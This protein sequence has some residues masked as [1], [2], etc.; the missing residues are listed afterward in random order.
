M[1]ADQKGRRQPRA[2]ERP[3]GDEAVAIILDYLCTRPQDDIAVFSMGPIISVNGAAY[4]G[5][6]TR[7][8]GEMFDALERRQNGTRKKQLVAQGDMTMVLKL[9][10]RHVEVKGVK[11]T[12]ATGHNGRADGP[13][14]LHQRVIG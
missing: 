3:V 4:C 5:R 10:Q 7:C 1:V 9:E 2:A 6:E 12:T 14:A 8:P 13:P 11:T